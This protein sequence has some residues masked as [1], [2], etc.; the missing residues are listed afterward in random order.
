MMLREEYTEEL[1]DASEDDEVDDSDEDANDEQNEDGDGATTVTAAEIDR[2]VF[3]GWEELDAYLSDFGD[4][5]HQ[6]RCPLLPDAHT[7]ALASRVI[8]VCSATRRRHRQGLLNGTTD[9]QSK[10]THAQA[11]TSRQSSF[12]MRRRS[13]VWATATTP[14]KRQAGERK[15]RDV[16]AALRRYVV[17]VLLLL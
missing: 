7:L 16:S 11:I 14:G 17:L 4:R 15:P 5:T 9:S 10:R 2:T 3:F 1:D 8:A 12:T 6:V 13:C